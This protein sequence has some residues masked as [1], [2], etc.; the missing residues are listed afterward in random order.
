[1]KKALSLLILLAMCLSMLTACFG[2]EWREQQE[3]PDEA[4]TGAANFLHNIMKDK[5]GAENLYDFDVV[6]K[7]VVE[8]VTY[9]VTWKTDNEKVKIVKSAKESYWTVDI[10]TTNETAFT[11]KLIAT[12]KNADGE[13][14]TKEFT[15]K[16]PVIS[17]DNTLIVSEPQEGV[18]Y[19]LFIVQY[20][21]RKLLFLT[22]TTQDGA[23]KFIEGAE[24]AA[25]GA[26]YQVEKVEGGYKFFTM[27][28]GV[29]NYVNAYIETYKD[30][31]N[32]DKTSKYL[33]F[34]TTDAAVFYH[35]QNVGAWFTMIDNAEFC[36]GT[37]A[38]Y[39]T[40]SLSEGS[41]MTEEAVANQ[42]QFAVQFVKADKASTL[43]PTFDQIIEPAD[44]STLTI[45]EAIEL[46]NKFK[47][48]SYSTGKF[49]I[50]GEITNIS[51]TKY[52]NML[53]T[54]GEKEIL[55]YGLYTANN[56]RYDAMDP[57]PVVGDT[58]TVKGVIG[59]YD[60]PQ[61]KDGTLLKL[62][63]EDYVEEGAEEGGIEL[64]L[65]GTTTR[66]S[67]AEDKI[68]HSGNG[69]TY[70]NDRGTEQTNALYNATEGST[71]ATRAFKHT[72]ITIEAESAF[73]RIVFVLYNNSDYITGFDGMTVEGAT[74]T[75]KNN[76]VTISFEED[77]TSFVSAALL[78]Q[79]RIEKIALYTTPGEAVEEESDGYVLVTAP[80]TGVGY[81]FRLNQ[82]TLNKKLYF[83]GATE[84]ESVTYRLASTED[85]AASTLVYLEAVEGV[86]GAFRM[87]FMNGEAKTYI[88]V[89]ERTASSKSGS[90]ELIT[91]APEEYF[92]FD[93]TYNTLV[94][95]SAETSAKYYIN[96]YNDFT[97]FSISNDTKVSMNY[98]ACLYTFEVAEDHE[99]SYQT[100][101]VAPTCTEQGYT[102]YTCSCNDSYKDD[103]QDALG[104]KDDIADNECDV[105]GEP[106]DP[107]H[108]HS[109]TETVTEPGC[110]T[111][112]YT[113]FTCSC[114]H[115][116]TGAE[117]NSLGHL[118]E[119]V[120]NECDRCGEPIDPNHQH[121]YAEVVT[122]PTCSAKGYTTF[123][124]SCG[125]TYIGAETEI[126]NHKDENG[127][128][129][130]DFDGCT[131]KFIPAADSVLTIEQALALGALF[132]END[133]YTDNK[134]YVTGTIKS[135]KDDTNALKYGNIYLTDG[136]ND[137]YV[138]GIYD[139][140]GDIR[141]ENL[142]GTKPAVGDTIT[143][144]GKIGHYYSTQM[145]SGWL[146]HN[147]ID[148]VTAPKC[149]VAG[150]TTHTCKWCADSYTDS[151]TA[152][153]EHNFVD[154]ICDRPGCG[155]S[156]HQHT[157]TPVV[158]DPTCT[159][160]GY[161]TYTCNCTDSYTDD[162]VDALGH[163]DE[164]GDFKCDRGGCTGLVLPED[165]AT[166]SIADALKIGVLTTTTEK[167]YVTGMIT[168]VY[169]TTY[170][171]MYITDGTDT[172]TVYGLYLGEKGNGGTQYK[173]MEVKP[174]AYDTIKIYGVLSSHNGSAQF[175]AASLI[176]HEVHVCS[177]YTEAT[178]EKKAECVVCGTKIGDYAD[179][180]M[181]Q[182]VCSVCGY[183]EGAAV[184]DTNTVTMA[185]TT[186]ETTNMTG[187]NDAATVGL[188]AT[189]FSVI[190]DKGD[191]NNN[192]GLN[193]AG[194]IRLYG[195][196]DTG[197]GSYFTV[198]IAEGYTIKSIKVTF[199]NSSNNKN[200][201]LTVGE[202]STTFDGSSTTWEVDINSDSFKLQNVITGSTTQI[203]I[204]SIEIT[205]TAPAAE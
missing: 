198:T 193:Q 166:I 99:H 173:D 111:G 69:I 131:E 11:Y 197:V 174:V 17:D 96:T 65:T 153:L 139:K 32:Q 49:V 186:A 204:S 119:T 94:Y 150:Y 86:D 14:V 13:T 3:Q 51:S 41:F 136:T 46:G 110:L 147:Y 121:S 56:T 101:V 183:V 100:T 80:Q 87:Y 108:Q 64:D 175:V 25:N 36:I 112:G 202:T 141:F 199:T 160:K 152:A 23:N 185:Y 191:T 79:V 98:V 72:T 52:G 55:I 157:Y 59:K 168:S 54:D 53:I 130:C 143:L 196:R 129:K 88:R 38:S 19:K 167:Y 93:T 26:I 201:Q 4:L 188:D 30:E 7:V 95:T 24:G 91:E 68:V 122:A 200:C 28:D 89:Y 70:T 125:H 20:S 154:G 58:V 81:Y 106:I 132:T 73:R 172:I 104:H 189:I 103:Y 135:F 126:V 15:R 35:K 48:D 181:V 12:I 83:A 10:P 76:I 1:M 127:D 123:S 178:C 57:Q 107:N 190:G 162:E 124:C 142:A 161:T 85:A 16:V 40:A 29:K 66:V 113:T 180:D 31:N 177:Q 137:L 62:N 203:Y 33:G 118:N 71:L 163:L 114:G 92:T 47:K 182:G 37:H 145:K 205:Y 187:N 42:E 67:Y 158:T 117:T 134:Y 140:T 148:E 90:L 176:E 109:Y 21:L 146:Q 9:E 156:N 61:M 74:I 138:Y 78:S 184:V 165:G 192:C 170:G 60:D 63:G 194:Q 120:D 84:S 44:G 8:G 133:D 144:Y 164:N 77:V 116:Y 34:S 18:D 45:A 27:I 105:C 169:N 149:G 155:V 102:L 5:E 179:H 151:E 128:Y 6:A 159:A 82:L 22:N 43:N 171:N 115:T 195:K 2:S 39:P 75:R 97:T 50:T